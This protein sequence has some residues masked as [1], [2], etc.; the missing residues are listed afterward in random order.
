MPTR[1][2]E[3]IHFP[4]RRLLIFGA[5][6][7]LAAS[8]R[9][10]VVTILGDSITAGHGVA[11]AEALPSRLQQAL[12]RLGVRAEVRGAGISGDTTAAGLGRVDS[13]VRPDTDVC[14]LALGGNDL[15]QGLDPS[16]TRAN[17]SA[18]VARL[19]ARRIRVVIAGVSAPPAIGR[20][21][22]HDFDAVF[23]AVARAQ[24][25]ALYPDLL[26]GVAG[27]PRLNQS[28]GIHPNPAGVR[29][30]AGHLAPVIARV[31][32]EGR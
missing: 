7:S 30:I 19:E 22:A 24:R 17:L 25:V 11:A 8:G 12:A 18:I 10:R 9:T 29:I 21:Y 15:L 14:L 4:T 26:A 2:L 16:V 3:Q 27:D 1:T 28:D 20:S 13:S 5:G 6:A 31:L 32:R 23:P